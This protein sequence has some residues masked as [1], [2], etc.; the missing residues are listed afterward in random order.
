M[1]IDAGSLRR[2]SLFAGVIRTL[3]RLQINADFG[4][5]EFEHGLVGNDSDCGDFQTQDG[6]GRE[7]EPEIDGTRVDAEGQRFEF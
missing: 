3:K 5:P 6:G 4:D 7:F 2:G 1:D